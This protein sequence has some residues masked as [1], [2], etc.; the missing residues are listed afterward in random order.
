MERVIKKINECLGTFVKAAASGPRDKSRPARTVVRRIEGGFLLVERYA[1]NKVTHEKIPEEECAKTV[2]ELV[3]NYR[4]TV[5]MFTDISM[6]VL[7]NGKGKITVRESPAARLMEA[8]HNRKKNYI[9]REGD[10]I[11]VMRDLGIF[12]KDN[13]VVVSKQDKYRQINRFI[14]TVND[15][16]G[17]EK[18]IYAVDFGCGK[19]YLTF[20]LYYFFTVKKCL[21]THIIGYDLKEDVVE[22]CNA[23]A[24]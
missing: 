19:S 6:T 12:T 18:E 8:V 16:L 23:L 4:Q 22:R 3:E 17:D 21:K 5:V 10:D 11:P 1:E 20:L 15:V 24:K 2:A 14:E 13:K 9:L 7:S